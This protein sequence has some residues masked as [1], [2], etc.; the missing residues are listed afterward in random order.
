[1]SRKRAFINK[2]REIDMNIDAILM[3]LIEYLYSIFM[4]WCQ[5]TDKKVIQI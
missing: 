1:M 4:K 5:A 3:C 2:F